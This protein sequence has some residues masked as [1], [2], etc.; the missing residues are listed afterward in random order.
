MTGFAKRLQVID[1]PHQ[2]RFPAVR[3]DMVHLS[4]KCLTSTPIARDTK[5]TIRED[6]LAQLAP[7]P[8]IMHTWIALRPHVL[9]MLITTT[10]GHKYWTVGM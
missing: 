3:E 8:T 4:C 1:F 9:A 10:I 5:R 7:S 2:S 6:P